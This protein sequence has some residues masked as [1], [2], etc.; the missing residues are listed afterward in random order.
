MLPTLVIAHEHLAAFK[1]DILDPEP[2]AFG[3]TH[4]RTIKKRYH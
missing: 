4:A 3:E 1:I 2:K